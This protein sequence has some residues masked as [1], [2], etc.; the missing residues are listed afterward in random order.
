MPKMCCHHSHV[1]AWLQPRD[2]CLAAL[3]GPLNIVPCANFALLPPQLTV[4]R[5]RYICLHIWELRKGGLSPRLVTEMAPDRRQWL[6]A[7][8]VEEA[9]DT[10]T[11]KFD[12]HVKYSATVI[13]CS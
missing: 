8:N 12:V 9:F 6:A 10:T 5:P 7:D 13:S 1:I 3:A 2:S 11:I 4:F